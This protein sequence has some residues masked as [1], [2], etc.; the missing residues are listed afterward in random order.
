[1]EITESR[2][3]AVTVVKPTGPL[4]RADTPAFKSRLAEATS[5]S[6]GRLVIDAGG[7]AFV[8]SAGLEAILDV[9]EQLGASGLT[10]KLCGL[11]ETVREVLELTG[12]T[13]GIEHYDDV[14]AAVRSFL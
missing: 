7:I 3:G 8:D 4:C 5:M 1:M 9:S 10:L 14:H 6:L 2:Q 11:N 12:L 13:E